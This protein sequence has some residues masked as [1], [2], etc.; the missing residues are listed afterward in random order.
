MGSWLRSF[1]TYFSVTGTKNV[2]RYSKDF[3]SS[4]RPLYQVS[5]LYHEHKI[6]KHYTKTFVGFE[7]ASIMCDILLVK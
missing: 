3:I 5:S 7:N 6:K 4:F 2:V 1:P